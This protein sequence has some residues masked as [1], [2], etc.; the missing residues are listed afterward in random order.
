MVSMA[1]MEQPRNQDDIPTRILL[2]A[3]MLSE[4]KTAFQ[5]GVVIFIPFIVVDMIVAS[6]LMAMGMIMLPPMMISLP[7]KVLLFVMA[8][9]WNLVVT[10][11]LKSFT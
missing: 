7:F 8:D 1:G 11:L 2:P 6:V 10:S 5:M 3:F 4:L 9:G